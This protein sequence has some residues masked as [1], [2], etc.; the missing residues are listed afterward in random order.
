MEHLSSM[1]PVT[2]CF[3]HVVG[4]LVEVYIHLI[5][6]RLTSLSLELLGA[7]VP[8]RDITYRG[9]PQVLQD[10]QSVEALAKLGGRGT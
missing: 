3:D 9:R 6:D 5:A 1:D 10:G 4:C 8:S 2:R 7:Q